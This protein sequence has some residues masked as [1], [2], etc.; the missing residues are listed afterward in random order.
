MRP[1]IPS[2]SGCALLLLLLLPGIASPADNGKQQELEDLRSR[3]ARLKDEVERAS[4]DRSEAADGLRN[5]ERKISDVNRALIELQKKEQ[6]LGLSLDELA[7]E[8]RLTKV[9]LHTERQQLAALLRQRYRQGSDDATRLALSGRDPSEIQRDLEYY[10]YIGRARVRL[11]RAHNTS[12]G[13]LAAVETE[14]R[15]RKADLEQIKQN[16][17]SQ[18]ATLD[19]EK[20]LRQSTY[21]Q[22]SDQ[23][24]QQRKQIDSLVRDEG[25]LSR[26]IERLQR[27]A[28]SRKIAKPRQPRGGKI[29]TNVADASLA[30]LKFAAL[31]GKLALPVAGELLARF[32]QAR[33]GGGPAWKGLFIRTK[34]GQP[35]RTVASGAV[36]F[37]DWLRGFGNLLIVDHGGGYLSLYSNN[38]SLYKQ[39]GD[40]VHAGDVIAATG[41]T[42]GQEETGLYFELRRQGQPFDPMS[43]VR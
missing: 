38:E 10:A 34:V 24:R 15:S 36:V 18:R 16:Q 29:V 2:L 30:G 23:V 8:H 43:W 19:K 32:G 1:P 41:D 27:L 40:T 39:A 12:L 21:N 31:K 35:V 22:L 4:A 28:E 13:R 5:S 3:I 42:G 25:R 33:A 17:L 37:A 7:Q 26:L 14:T 20:R 11:V 9:Q 6:R